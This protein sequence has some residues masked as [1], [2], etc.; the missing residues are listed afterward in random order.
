M[1]V[2]FVFN[3]CWYTQLQIGQRR[4]RHQE[5]RH[6]GTLILQLMY[7]LQISPPSPSLLPSSTLCHT[8]TDSLLLHIPTSPNHAHCAMTSHHRGRRTMTA[9]MA[10]RG[11]VSL[12]CNCHNSSKS[13]TCSMIT[14][15]RAILTLCLLCECIYTYTYMHTCIHT[16]N[17]T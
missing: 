14:R 17:H 2:V 15:N 6:I 4:E 8:P 16:Y 11:G 1:C 7:V 3:A 13:W 12:E 9:S 5:N 10:P